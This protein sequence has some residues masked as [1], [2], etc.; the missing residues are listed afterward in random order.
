[1]RNSEEIRMDLILLE[2]LNKTYREEIL[3]N[4]KDMEILLAEYNKA[5][6]AEQAFAEKEGQLKIVEKHL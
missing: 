5:E 1:M 4:Q 3:D 2:R 6:E